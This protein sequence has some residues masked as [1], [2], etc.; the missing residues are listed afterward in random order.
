M[1]LP[2]PSSAR[3][4]H[5]LESQSCLFLLSR[6]VPGESRTITESKAQTPLAILQGAGLRELQRCEEPQGRESSCWGWD[7]PSARDRTG[8]AA[9]KCPA[10]HKGLSHDSTAGVPGPMLPP[11][12]PNH[13][14]TAETGDRFLHGKPLRPAQPAWK[15]I[16]Q[17]ASATGSCMGHGTAGCPGLNHPEQTAVLPSV[18]RG[19]DPACGACPLLAGVMAVP[20]SQD[21]ASIQLSAL[22]TTFPKYLL[23]KT[24][25]LLRA[26]T[27]TEHLPNG[28]SA[29]HKIQTQAGLKK[30]RP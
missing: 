27:N 7:S 22:S 18:P 21:T 15:A 8:E 11:T 2:Q 16:W 29:K 19:A 1:L 26:L 14:A 3:L 28:S 23:A 20:V 6:L 30:S 17:S 25:G 5:E 24:A 9:A 13:A 10:R 12:I 4:S